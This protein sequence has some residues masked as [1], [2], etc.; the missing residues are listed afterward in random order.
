MSNNTAR[1]LRV[2]RPLRRQSSRLVVALYRRGLGPACGQLAAPAHYPRTPQRPSIHDT[3]RLRVRRPV[4]T[5]SST[6]DGGLPLPRRARRCRLARQPARPARGHGADRPAPLPGPAPASSAASGS[7]ASPSPATCTGAPYRHERPAGP[8]VWIAP[9]PTRASP[10]PPA[11][12]SPSSSRC[13]STAPRRRTAPETV[14]RRT[15]FC[16]RLSAST[17]MM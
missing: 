17:S 14:Q 2:A 3:H 4:G 5:A 15:N 1:L 6:G 10:K 16:I 11:P 12:P 9:D 13:A 7:A 8:S